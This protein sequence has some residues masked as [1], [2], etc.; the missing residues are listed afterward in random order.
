MSLNDFIFF[1]LSDYSF[2]M[3]LLLI[4]NATWLNYV[5]CNFMCALHNF[6]TVDPIDHLLQICKLRLSPAS[7]VISPITKVTRPLFKCSAHSQLVSEVQVSWKLYRR[8]GNSDQAIRYN[9]LHDDQ[10]C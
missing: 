1:S 5:Y 9:L 2:K 10:L 4:I 3:H 8:F 7:T 6:L